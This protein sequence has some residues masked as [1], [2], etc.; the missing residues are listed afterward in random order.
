MRVHAHRV[1]LRG[2]FCWCD[3]SSGVSGSP[4]SPPPPTSYLPST[5]PCTHSGINRAGGCQEGCHVFDLTWFC[6][7]M[8]STSGEHPLLPPSLPQPP[9]T[10]RGGVRGAGCQLQCRSGLT[11]WVGNWLGTA[12]N[13]KAAPAPGMWARPLLQ[14]GL[15]SFWFGGGVGERSLP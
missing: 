1:V 13:H 10:C 9:F 3:S 7:H 8:F 14:P 15:A 2:G 12:V 4:F 6:S 11:P 5:R